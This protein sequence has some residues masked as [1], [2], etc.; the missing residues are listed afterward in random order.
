MYKSKTEIKHVETSGFETDVIFLKN[1]D[2]FSWDKIF[3]NLY[4]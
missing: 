4:E 1:T 3:K 2:E